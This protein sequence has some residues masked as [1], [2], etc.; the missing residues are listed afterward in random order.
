LKHETPSHLQWTDSPLRFSPI[1]L[2]DWIT[3]MQGIEL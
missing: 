2:S 1:P 3:V